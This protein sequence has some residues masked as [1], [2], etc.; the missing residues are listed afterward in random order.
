MFDDDIL[1]L[2]NLNRLPY[3]R[4]WLGRKKTD[5][6]VDYLKN[7][8]P[9]LQE[10][11]VFAFPAVKDDEDLWAVEGSEFVFIT[12]DRGVARDLV[13]GFCKKK[14]IPYINVGYDGHHV[15]IYKRMFSTE[16]TDEG[17]YTVTPSWA[18][19]TMAIAGLAMYHMCY[20]LTSERT[21]SV[22]L[23]EL[24]GFQEKHKCDTCGKEF[25]NPWDM[26]SH[27]MWCPICRNE[28]HSEEEYL[29]H[30][31]FACEVCGRASCKKNTISAHNRYKCSCGFRT[32]LKS[33][34][35]EHMTSSGHTP[36]TETPAE[37]EVE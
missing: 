15:S 1:T 24:M 33:L 12:A 11:D 4:E 31:K 35:D 5:C 13:T 10:F 34:L 19:P 21:F 2:T 22:N 29:A 30:Y 36:I 32:C 17:G 18:G 7:L 25:E 23:L 8:M 20:P 14:D 3:P 16:E 9:K 27:T 6:I 26:E 28:F 37:P